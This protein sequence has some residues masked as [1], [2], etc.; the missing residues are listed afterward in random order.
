[1]SSAPSKT[2]G[3]GFGLGLGLFYAA[4]FMVGYLMMFTAADFLIRDSIKDKE[5]ELVEERLAEYRAWYLSGQW[6][7]LESRFIEQGR[8]NGDLMFVRLVGPNVGAFLFSA[9]KGDDLLDVQALNELAESGEGLSATITSPNSGEVWTVAS[10]PLR[11]GSV[12]QAGRL[13]TTAFNSAAIFR[14]ISLGTLVPGVLISLAGG[15][16]LAYRAMKPVRDLSSTVAAIIDTG[17]LDRRVELDPGRGDLLEMSVLFNRMLERNQSLIRAMRESLDNVAHDLRTPMARM[18]ATAEEALATG[19]DPEAKQSALADCMEESERVLTMLNT[20]MDISEAESG[21]M[22]LHV[23]E[24]DLVALVHQVVELYELVGEERNVS[25]DTELPDALTV[26]GDRVRLQQVIANL[27]DNAVKYVEEGGHVKITVRR[28]GS[29]A[30]IRVEDDGPGIP[31]ADL[32]RI[33]ERLYRGDQSRSEKR[34]LGL[35]LSFVKAIVDAHGGR[36]SVSSRAGEGSVFE[37]R[38]PLP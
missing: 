16:F 38:L 36:V 4:C 21:A 24:V 27:T 12:L 10:T 5:R 26:D 2:T 15:M 37:V 6:S 28:E 14:R 17:D 7:G 11:G 18:R 8:R 23:E 9:P 20:L 22:R 35:G 34:G 29:E 19:G 1:M 31:E 30:V 33:W 32:S 25:I 13:S 3:L